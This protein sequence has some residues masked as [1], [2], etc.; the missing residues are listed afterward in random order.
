MIALFIVIGA[1]LGI[2]AFV[3]VLTSKQNCQTKEKLL[4]I[5]TN[6]R[7][8]FETDLSN[9]E[10]R[11]QDSNEKDMKPIDELS[12]GLAMAKLG[13]YPEFDKTIGGGDDALNT[14]FSETGASKHVPRA[15]MSVYY[16]IDYP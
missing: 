15:R 16:P 3:M 10:R 13:A 2:A 7:D 6:A 4:T 9:V 1:C 11:R 14:F 8:R 12:P 5:N